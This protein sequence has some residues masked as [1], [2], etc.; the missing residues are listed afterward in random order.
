MMTPLVTG[1]D[2]FAEILMLRTADPRTVVLLEGPSDCQAVDAHVDDT[3][4][5]TLPGYSKT[6]VEKAI[7]LADAASLER[8]LAILD[9]DWVGLL[10]QP[11]ASVNVVYTDYYDLDATVYLS[12]DVMTRVVGTTTDRDHL[13][14]Y[15]D[16]VGLSL[17]EII[18]R[19][20]GKVGV[21]R[22]ISCRDELHISFRDFPV[23]AALT[24]NHDDIDMAQMVT[25]ALGR[26]HSPSVQRTEFLA[27]I[28]GRLDATTD[29]SRYCSGHD[30]ATVIAHLV[31]NR[32]GGS[33]VSRATMEQF[34]KA[35]LSCAALQQ[36]AVYEKVAIWATRAG[37]RV[38]SCE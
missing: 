34:G 35:A 16:T 17:R 33:N 24:A 21:G 30:I 15:L 27:K 22:F 32:W 10:E 38:W 28:R 14:T 36:T 7:Q 5:H 9:L 1:D 3:A 2:L 18:V 11:I 13:A 19:L 20:A 8:V 29:L 12:A 25:V 31:K 23:N 26:A 37:T 6:A 4:A